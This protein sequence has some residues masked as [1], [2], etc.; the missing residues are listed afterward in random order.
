MIETLKGPILVMGA[1]GFIGANL[2]RKLL[3]VR[4]DVYGTFFSKGERLKGLPN[5]IEV[6]LTKYP[7]T[8]LNKVKPA[9]VFDLV[10]YGAYSSETDTARI[11]ETNVLFKMRLMEFLY[12]L[13]TTQ[14]Y[15]HA[16]SSSEYGEQA[17]G[18]SENSPLLANSHYAVSKA[19][20]SALIH[21]WGRHRGIRCA[22]LR[23]YSVYGPMEDSSRL[24]PKL[25][26]AALAG[27]YPPL[28]NP[29]VSRDFVYVDDVCDVFIRT[30]AH[31]SPLMYG[32]SFNIG[33]GVST[34]IWELARI[35]KSLF[36]IDS[37][38]EFSTMP[39]RSWDFYG[40]WRANRDKTYSCLGWESTTSIR[41]GLLRY[42]EWLKN[43]LNK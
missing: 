41:E 35:S 20:T 8:T 19:A 33:T 13:R 1:S 22:N 7:L 29:R 11:Y 16:G 9:T 5:I 30:A 15:I 4:Q 6:D 36:S 2:F 38:P 24:I 18:P 31:L 12:Q 43:G 32:H 42:A 23:L 40:K 37:E 21:Y 27:T 39:D 28:V 3:N 10:T 25:V 26:S 14:C 17:D 34:T